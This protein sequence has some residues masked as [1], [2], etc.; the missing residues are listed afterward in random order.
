MFDSDIRMAVL[1]PDDIPTRKHA[2][3]S[4]SL[5]DDGKYPPK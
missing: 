2:Q 3:I 4:E 1:A 5:V